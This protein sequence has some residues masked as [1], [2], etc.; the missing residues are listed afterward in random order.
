MMLSQVDQPLPRAA[1]KPATTSVGY[2]LRTLSGFPVI[3]IL[4]RYAVRTLRQPL[5]HAQLD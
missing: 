3:A 5:P 1:F 4:K 2:A